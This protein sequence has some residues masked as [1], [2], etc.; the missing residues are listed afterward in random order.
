[1][2]QGAIG[3]GIDRHYLLYITAA[4]GVLLAAWPLPDS[5]AQ[6][7]AR[8]ISPSPA[9]VDHPLAGIVEL[10]AFVSLLQ[11][12]HRLSSFYEPLIL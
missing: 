9:V 2:S 10:V 1:M 6:I 8:T 3:G 4:D 7:L 5:P 11:M 12:L